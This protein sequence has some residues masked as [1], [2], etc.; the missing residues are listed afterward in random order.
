MNSPEN[1]SP[2]L[3]GASQI[4]GGFAHSHALGNIVNI[5]DA[6]DVGFDNL[7][8]MMG[9]VYLDF[10]NTDPGQ[11]NAGSVKPTSTV[12]CTVI[13]TVGPVLKTITRKNFLVRSECVIILNG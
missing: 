6:Q 7:G 5:A 4:V 2:H 10:C 1:S 3:Q 8:P 13:P 12:K 11:F 9:K